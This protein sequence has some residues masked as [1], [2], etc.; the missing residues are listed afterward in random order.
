MW[1]SVPISISTR[2]N[3]YKEFKF[4]QS[5]IKALMEAFA[6]LQLV[7]LNLV[8]LV[9]SHFKKFARSTISFSNETSFRI[10]SRNFSWFILINFAM[11]SDLLYLLFSRHNVLTLYE[12]KQLCLS[13]WS[14]YL[15]Y[16][17]DF[18]MIFFNDSLE[19]SVKIY[20]LISRF[21]RHSSLIASFLFMLIWGFSQRIM[22]SKK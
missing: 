7:R 13:L 12:W 14:L 15:I 19:S 11:K 9:F 17:I 21:Y 22:S 20:S 1:L 5:W 4:L 18:L 16:I 6:S 2:V 10:N 8:M 3:S